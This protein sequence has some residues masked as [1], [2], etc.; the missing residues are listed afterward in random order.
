MGGNTVVFVV[1]LVPCDGCYPQR[2]G[3]VCQVLVCWPHII[4]CHQQ[5]GCHLDNRYSFDT[6]QFTPKIADSKQD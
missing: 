2:V 6:L 5:Q 1:E 4:K 3:E